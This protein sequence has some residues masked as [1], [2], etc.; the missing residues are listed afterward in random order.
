ME[1]E[2]MKHEDL[3]RKIIRCAYRVYNNPDL[4]GWLFGICVRKIFI[5]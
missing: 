1:D 4:S 5:D 2:I 3:S